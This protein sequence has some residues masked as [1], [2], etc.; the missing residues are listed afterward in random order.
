MINHDY[1]YKKGQTIS[2]YSN[3]MNGRYVPLQ[4]RLGELMLLNDKQNMALQAIQGLIQYATFLA[5]TIPPAEDESKQIRDLATWMAI[6]YGIDNNMV[7][8]VPNCS[9]KGH[10]PQFNEEHRRTILQGLSIYIVDLKQ[11]MDPGLEADIQL[12]GK[13]VQEMKEWEQ[14]D[15]TIAAALDGLYAYAKYLAAVNMEAHREKVEDIWDL[16]EQIITYFEIDE[17]KREK[18]LNAIKYLLDGADR[19]ILPESISIQKTA[20]YKG[21]NY[22]QNEII[23]EFDEEDCQNIK[24]QCETIM[25]NLINNTDNYSPEWTEIQ[26]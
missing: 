21:I 2:H 19:V 1:A 4:P 17:M 3:V 26:M 14:V 23:G 5:G 12:C 20:I 22:Y 9:G 11:D 10:A 25:Q 24:K 8:A 15:K 16:S 6:Y 18:Y 13:I 7:V